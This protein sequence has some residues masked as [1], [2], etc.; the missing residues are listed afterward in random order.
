MKP[1]ITNLRNAYKNKIDLEEI[2]IIKTEKSIPNAIIV[3]AIDVSLRASETTDSENV[4]NYV[5]PVADMIFHIVILGNITNIDISTVFQTGVDNTVDRMVEFMDMAEGLGL[6]KIVESMPNYERAVRLFESQI[7]AN[8]TS[9]NS[10]R[11]VL[12]GLPNSNELGEFSEELK[13]IVDSLNIVTDFT[14]PKP[15]ED[16]VIQSDP[17]DLDL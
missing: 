9:Y 16:T 8:L 7:E 13:G 15:I 4:T 11:G 17:N 1:N 6:M 2:E 5:I 12:D 14:H 10:L 3:N